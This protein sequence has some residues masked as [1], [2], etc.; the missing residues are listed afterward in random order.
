MGGSD[1][2]RLQLLLSLNYVS[3]HFFIT[4]ASLLSYYGIFHSLATHRRGGWGLQGLHL[5]SSVLSLLVDL[6]AAF[7]RDMSRSEVQR[8]AGAA[9]SHLSPSGAAD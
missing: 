8:G 3:Q 7:L 6:E 2:A 5:K 9:A 1:M 4:A